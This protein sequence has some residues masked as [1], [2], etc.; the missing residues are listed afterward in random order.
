MLSRIAAGDRRRRREASLMASS[1][2]CHPRKQREPD[3]G[4][5]TGWSGAPGSRTASASPPGYDSDNQLAEWIWIRSARSASGPTSVAS[6]IRPI[7]QPP[8][9]EIEYRARPGSALSDRDAASGAATPWRSI[10]PGS[11]TATRRVVVVPR[12]WPRGPHAPSRTGGNG[13]FRRDRASSPAAAFDHDD[14]LV[15]GLSAAPCARRLARSHARRGV[16]SWRHR[17]RPIQLGSTVTWTYWC[18]NGAGRHD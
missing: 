6:L 13:R 10:T 16:A 9:A 15:T 4:S 2:P 7:A 18:A 5:L 14:S 12:N 8:A 17:P 1:G 3:T 11:S